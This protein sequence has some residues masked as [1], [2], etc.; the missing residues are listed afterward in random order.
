ME[1]LNNKN[2][3]LGRNLEETEGRLKIAD[4]ENKRLK[5][6]IGKMERTLKESEVAIERLQKEKDDAIQSAAAQAQE[7]QTK[8][9]NLERRAKLKEQ[10]ALAAKKD[11]ET[12]G[13]EKAAIEKE[14][15][16]SRDNVR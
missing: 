14:L 6:E 10:E 8:I 16:N 3:D 2:E 11:A 9:E 13:K 15:Q 5:E 12:I 1:R 7:A 4:E